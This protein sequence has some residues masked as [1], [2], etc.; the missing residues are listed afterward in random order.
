MDMSLLF[1]GMLLKH[2]FMF[3]QMRVDATYQSI[4]IDPRLRLLEEYY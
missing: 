1:L 2:S 3:Y 4:N